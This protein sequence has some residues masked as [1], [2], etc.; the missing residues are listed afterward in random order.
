MDNAGYWLY[1]GKAKPDDESGVRCHLLVYHSLDVAAVGYEYLAQSRFFH[2][3][4][5]RFF[6]GASKDVLQFWLAFWWALHDLGKFAEAFQGLRP[7]LL[8]ALQKRDYDRNKVYGKRHDTLG[9]WLWKQNL[10]QE[11]QSGRWF[12]KASDFLSCELLDA[13]VQAV[14][15]HHGQ[16]PEALLGGMWNTYFHDRDQQAALAFVLEMRDLFLQS[17]PDAAHF[18][19]AQE[20]EGFI[21]NSRKFSWWM[22]GITVLSDWLGSNADFFPYCDTPMPLSDYWEKARRQA[23]AALAKSGVQS[24]PDTDEMAF[25]ALFP[26]ISMP[27]PLQTWATQV[28]ISKDPHLFLL[29]DVTGAGKTEAAVILAHRLMAAGAA[30]G[31]FIGLPSMA[32]ANAMYERIAQVYE[33]LFSGDASLVLAHGQRDLVEAFAASVLPAGPMEHD[34]ITQEASATARCTAWLADHNKRA[35]LATAGVGTVDQALLAVLRSRHQSL[36]LLGLLGKVLIVDEVH[37]CD[38]YMQKVLEVLLHYHAQAGGSA[39]LLSATLPQQMKR[40]LLKAFAEGCEQSAP[41]L[42]KDEYPLATVW[43]DET[44][45]VVDE[46]S[47]ATRKEVS[48]TLNL[49]YLHEEEDVIQV[50]EAALNRGQCVCWMRNTIKDAL[51]AHEQFRDKLAE[52]QRILFHSRF[53]LEDRLEIE[54]RILDCFGKNSDAEKRRGKL[55]IATQVVEQSL[56]ADWDVVISDLAPIDRLIQR[57]GRLRRHCRDATGKLLSAE[58]QDQRGAAHFYVHGPEW[59][60]E[61]QANWLKAK[62]SGTAAVYLHHGRMWRTAQLLQQGT[63]TMPDQA[64]QLIE[65]VFGSEAGLP[66]GLQAN[67]V[68]IEGQEYADVGMAQM[69][70]LKFKGGYARGGIDW[71][72]EARTPSRLGEA[73]VQVLLACWE[74]GHLRPWSQKSCDT[75]RHAWAYSAL[76]VP[77]RLIAKG[78]TPLAAEQTYAALLETLPG[79]GQWSVV[80]VLEEVAGVWQG[81]AVDEKEKRTCW[82][83]NPVSGLQAADK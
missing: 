14:M 78:I 36:R 63:M 40:S 44:P 53:T 27:S 60:A 22:A 11:A 49:H 65:A 34:P 56:D 31:F 51:T 70:T 18:I 68:R 69:N 16:P 39:I 67:E 58:L 38:A 33:H 32:T 43:R 59:T 6:P 42:L 3:L 17:S 2:R 46:I 8:R 81:W 5:Q 45:E 41:R 13:W 83:Y 74:A 29:E 55:V 26:K 9:W 66:T 10:Q 37:A 61:P 57:A 52:G 30:E 77:A 20:I 54:N 4:L 50:I 28:S 75:L 1:W 62:F 48:R 64:R 21:G 79:K 35:L 12:G 23:R 82:R 7:D 25:S 80:L 19:D 24:R 71:W 47:I 73:S 76:R 72:D 15:G